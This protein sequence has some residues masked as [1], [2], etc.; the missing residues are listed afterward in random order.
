MDK[1]IICSFLS[2][3]LLS[4]A[5]V[6]VPLTIRPKSLDLMIGPII[7]LLYAHRIAELSNVLK[8]PQNFKAS[9][10]RTQLN[11]RRAV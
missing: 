7:L 8:N 5:C 6:S 4:G 2:L 3:A 11:L 1:L 10:L 9:R